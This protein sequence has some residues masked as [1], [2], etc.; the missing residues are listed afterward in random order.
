MPIPIGSD[1]SAFAIMYASPASMTT[2]SRVTSGRGTNLAYSKA[3]T[4][5]TRYAARGRIH[6]SGMAAMF[7]V[8]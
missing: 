4:N 6:S 2:S 3:M 5:V 1:T 7:A 8:R